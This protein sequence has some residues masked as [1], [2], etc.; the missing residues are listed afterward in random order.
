V[1]QEVV[2][3]LIA[4]PHLCSAVDSSKKSVVRKFFREREGAG[5]DLLF[6]HFEALTCTT[7]IGFGGRT[8]YRRAMSNAFEY[9]VELNSS[10]GCCS[11][12]TRKPSAAHDAHSKRSECCT[13]SRTCSIDAH[14]DAA[15]S[16]AGPG[17][18]V[19]DRLNADCVESR[20]L[21]V[22]AGEV[23]G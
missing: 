12:A 9:E 1:L 6:D 15:M 10:M 19:A 7:Q 20:K 3:Y 18:V 5:V 17:D 21:P 8:S 2:E 16:A 13:E 22:S 23:Y 4:G 14:G 11:D